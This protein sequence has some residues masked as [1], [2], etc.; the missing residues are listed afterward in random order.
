MF[1]ILEQDSSVLLWE[2]WD[3]RI[4]RYHRRLYTWDS[5]AIG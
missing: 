3:W 4:T 1:G 2:H 5:S